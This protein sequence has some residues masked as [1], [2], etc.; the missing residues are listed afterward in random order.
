MAVD[1][2]C[3]FRFQDERISDMWA[4]EDTWTRN[5]NSD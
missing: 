2:V 1:K 5:A 3:F 4:I